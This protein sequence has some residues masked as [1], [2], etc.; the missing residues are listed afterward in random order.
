MVGFICPV[1]PPKSPVCICQGSGLI[2]CLT[3]DTHNVGNPDR[4]DLFHSWKVSLSSPHQV[5][6]ANPQADHGQTKTG[7]PIFGVLGQVLLEE[8]DC[9][10]WI[11]AVEQASL[12]FKYLATACPVFPQRPTC[13][14]RNVKTSK[15]FSA[16]NE[17]AG[18]RRI[19]HGKEDALPKRQRVP[20]E[21]EE[22]KKTRDNS[23]RAGARLRGQ[24]A[25]GLLRVLPGR[26]SVAPGLCQRT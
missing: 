13:R 18:V 4:L 24:R 23:H 16:G 7:E 8:L 3:Q 19:R 17:V 26:C 5:R 22:A 25:T 10:G 2:P 9:F 11:E 21:P 1:V 14:K 20:V 12:L 6:A 15:A